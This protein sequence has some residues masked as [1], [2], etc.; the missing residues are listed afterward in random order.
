[1]SGGAHRRMLNSVVKNVA[2]EIF[3]AEDAEDAEGAEGIPLVD[4]D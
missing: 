2:L 3:N 4:K 1:M